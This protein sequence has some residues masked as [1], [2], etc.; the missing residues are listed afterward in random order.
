MTVSE[1]KQEFIQDYGEAYQSFGLPKLM[2]R[3]VGLM[4]YYR[5]PLSLPQI[6]TELNVSK[7]PVSQVTKRLLD[8]NLIQAVWVPGDR[9][10]YYQ[11]T[12]DI[13]G[14]AFYNILRAQK[15]NLQL[16]K[17]YQDLQQKYPDPSNTS[18]KISVDKMAEFYELMIDHFEKF[19]NLWISH[20]KGS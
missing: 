6:T 5:K 20:E 14:C 7:G 9:K 8:H 17:K 3:V 1:V 19:Y 4:L 10:S 13:F 18:F 12:P 11:I 15:R 2:G 16:A